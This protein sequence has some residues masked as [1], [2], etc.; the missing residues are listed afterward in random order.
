MT[1]KDDLEKAAEER[2]KLIELA[3]TAKDVILIKA[4]IDKLEGEDS[5]VI[6]PEEVEHVPAIVEEVLY[7]GQ[8]DVSDLHHTVAVGE[9]I[10]QVRRVLGLLDPNEKAVAEALFGIGRSEGMSPE[11]A[12]KHLSMSIDDVLNHWASAQDKLRAN[13]RI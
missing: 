1:G 9:V 5:P 8:R 6:E 3:A 7:P 10:A 12:A 4:I 13:I 2:R 11:A